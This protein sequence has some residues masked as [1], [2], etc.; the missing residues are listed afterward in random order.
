MTRI[1]HVGLFG[2]TFDPPH[3]GHLSVANDIVDALE[4]DELRWVV[5]ARSPHKPD[6]ALSPDEVRMAMVSDVVQASPRFVLDDREVRRGGLSYAVDTLSDVRNEL[7]PDDRLY[8]II[9][10][11]Q[12]EVFDSWR[13][14]D[15]I[16]ELATVVVMDRE[17]SGG[18][19]PPDLSLEVGRVDISSTIVRHKAKHGEPLDELVTAGVARII[20]TY[21]LYRR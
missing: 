13:S 9:G 7:G 2:G 20:E 16:R 15:T 19:H 10:A 11:D 17:G 14:P 12:Y 6:T 5:A 8:L 4:L 3:L 1:R 18:A 21:G